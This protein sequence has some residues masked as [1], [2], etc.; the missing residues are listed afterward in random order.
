MFLPCWYPASSLARVEALKS[1][2][3]MF[4]CGSYTSNGENIFQQT[5]AA[6]SPAILYGSCP[7]LGDYPALRMRSEG[8]SDSSWT[9]LHV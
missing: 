2:A 5:L 8:S 9:G 4:E 1:K 6:I 3:T 7:L